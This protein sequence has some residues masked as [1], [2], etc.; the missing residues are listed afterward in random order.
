MEARPGVPATTKNV[1]TRTEEITIT[2]TQEKPRAPHLTKT[3]TAQEKI[4]KQQTQAPKQKMQTATTE[5]TKNKTME[6][7][8][9]QRYPFN[10]AARALGRTN[11]IGMADLERRFE[12]RALGFKLTT[13][14][15]QETLR[16]LLP[17]LLIPPAQRSAKFLEVSQIGICAGT[18]SSYWTT[19]LSLETCLCPKETSPDAKKIRTHLNHLADIEAACL[20]RPTC[21][22]MEIRVWVRAEGLPERWATAMMVTFV[23][24]QRFSDICLLQGRCLQIMG[25]RL[26]VTFLEGKTIPCTGPYTIHLELKSL[27]AQRILHLLSSDPLRRIFVQPDETYDEVRMGTHTHMSRDVRCLRRG[28]L[29][30]MALMGRTIPEILLFSRHKSTAMLMKYLQNG[31]VLT[32]QAEVTS[33]IVKSMESVEQ[34]P[35][36]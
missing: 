3:R 1:Y 28:G 2:R 6:D 23:L 13:V 11:A 25:D 32:A 15:Y 29:Q 16:R 21:T 5:K 36:A 26:A 9:P 27:C 22:T 12:E 20:D 7:K 4:T 19:I 34:W 35:W 10:E 14:G 24:G 33:D 31:K 8:Q 17:F 18:R 30:A